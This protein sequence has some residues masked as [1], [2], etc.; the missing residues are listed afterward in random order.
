MSA[1]LLL[2]CASTSV[3]LTRDAAT[4]ESF[5]AFDAQT[6]R[7]LDALLSDA[8]GETLVHEA[9]RLNTARRTCARHVLTGLLAL[10][11]SQGMEAVQQELNALSR[12]WRQDDLRAL[13]TEAL[14][15]DA[16]ALEP[17]VLEARGAVNRHAAAGR[18]ERRD[19]AE[20]IELKVDAPEGT[21]PEVPESMCDEHDPCAQLRCLVE[22]PPASPDAAARACLDAATALE[23]KARAQRAT[24]VLALLPST[25]GPAGTEARM[26]LETL[27]T[28]LWPQVESARA[29]KQPGRAAQLASLFRTLPS[30]SVRVEQLRDEAQAHH[31]ARA[32][33]V[34]ASAQSVW[35]HRRL[36]EDFGGPEAPPLSAVGKWESPRWRCKAPM[37]TLPELPAG[38]GATLNLRCDEAQP[39]L[40]K[41]NGDDSMRTFELEKSLK[42]QRLDGNLHVTCANSSSSYAL[43]VEDAGV[44]GFPEEALGQE[45]KRVLARSVSDCARLHAVAAPGSCA[46]LK[47]RGAGEIITRFVD[48]ARFLGRWEPC[49]EAWLL[50]TEGVAPPAP[51]ARPE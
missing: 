39:S 28:Q 33:A 15:E 30:V 42:G 23:P 5:A 40:R 9:S 19:D 41:S 3:Q 8:P 32:K 17:L 31:L 26:M 12:T 49:F 27:K 47:K 13:I 46:E 29:A 4:C 1:L 25:P 37:P 44:E 6:R 51:P 20:R 14:G 43:H 18:A 7:R 36:A 24:E 11:E 10:R 48:H 45:L 34:A 21:A 50:A 35:L 38:L 2:S 22:R 16:T